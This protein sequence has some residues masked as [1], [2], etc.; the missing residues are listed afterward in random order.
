MTVSTFTVPTGDSF[1]ASLQFVDAKGNVGAAP[2]GVV[3]VWTVDN[4]A[5]LV[6][7]PSTDGL[8]ADLV[9]VGPSGVAKVTVT[10]GTLT[11]EL[12]VTVEA[13][14]I[15]SITVVPGAIVTPAA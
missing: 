8:T 13:G 11:G 2:A 9:T 5:I 1:P 3:P 4:T 7:T 12:D 6:V 14:V 15:A 10:D